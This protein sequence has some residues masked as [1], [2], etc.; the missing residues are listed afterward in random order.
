MMIKKILAIL[1]DLVIIILLSIFSILI[2]SNSLGKY[3]ITTLEERGVSLFPIVVIFGSIAILYFAFA[4]ANKWSSLGRIFMNVVKKEAFRNRYFHRSLLALIVDF[5]TIVLM[6][7][8]IDCIINDFFYLPYFH[9]LSIVLFIFHIVAGWLKGKTIGKINSGIEIIGKNSNQ[10]LIQ[11]LKREVV[12]KFGL[13]FLLPA[14]L[15][16]LIGIAEPFNIFM[17]VIWL[18][19]IFIIMYYV[20]TGKL[21]WNDLAQT[22]KGIVRLSKKDKIVNYCVTVF[23]IASL[24]LFLR[25]SNNKIQDPKTKVFGFNYPLYY[26]EYPTNSRVNKYTDFLAKQNTSPRDYILNLFEKYDIVVLA[27]SYHGESTQWELISEIVSD[28]RFVQ[29]VGNVFTEYGSKRHQNKVD[30]FL[31]TVY[32]S[33]KEVE[34]ASASLMEYMSGGFYYFMKNLNKLNCTLPDSLKVREHYTDILDWD[35]LATY[36]YYE[37]NLNLDQ[38]DS[39]MAQ[40]TI[41]WYK[42]NLQRGKKRK[43]LVVTNTRHAFGYAGGIEKIK[44]LDIYHVSSGNQG[45]YIFEAFPQTTACIVQ[46]SINDKTKSVFMPLSMPIHSGIWEKAFKQNHYKPVGFDLADSPFGKD[47]LDFHPLRGDGTKVLY[48]D[49]FTG[50]IFNQPY[51]AEKE[52]DYPFK[53]YAIEKE[54]LQKFP[55]TDT[56]IVY[57]KVKQIR[58]NEFNR[59][60]AKNSN[61]Q[62]FLKQVNKIGFLSLVIILLLSSLSI[63]LLTVNLSIQFVKKQP[64]TNEG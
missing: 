49:I 53:R 29:N 50:V 39:L 8:A 64:N 46:N 13:S 41:D 55:N 60:E 58:G 14:L 27:E 47:K 18:S 28:K 37:K 12:F 56:A 35:Y 42:N 31:R 59:N 34:K 25:Y 5:T 44:K 21:W 23:I 26:P 6:T 17:N 54:Y 45:Q 10:S 36:R 57:R 63:V 20:L 62:S 19:G 22:K 61:P 51:Q 40:V 48:Q 3:S 9:L 43:C 15:F 24:L 4:A 1:I 11:S 2:V 30:T 52:V 38:R 33:D 7:S 32:S 16:N